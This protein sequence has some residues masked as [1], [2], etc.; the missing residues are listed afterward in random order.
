MDR[1]LGEI[2]GNTE[3]SYPKIKLAKLL[4]FKFLQFFDVL[5]NLEGL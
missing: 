5:R 1:Y 3:G 4:I 2:S